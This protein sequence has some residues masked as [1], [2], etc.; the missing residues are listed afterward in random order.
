MVTAVCAI[1]LSIAQV[2]AEDQFLVDEGKAYAEIG[3]SES[4]T[5]SAR[6]AAAELQSYVAKISG[7]WLPIAAEAEDGTLFIIHDQQR[8]MPKGEVLMATF[9]EETV[10]PVPTGRLIQPL[11]IILALQ[12]RMLSLEL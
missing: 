9:K 11:R 4:P 8:Y 12:S 7:E 5:R 10:G 3:I 6:L 1:S 2:K